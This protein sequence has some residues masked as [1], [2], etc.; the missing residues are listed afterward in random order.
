M[1]IDEAKKKLNKLFGEKGKELDPDDFLAGLQELSH[2][3]KAVQSEKIS[4]A[5]AQ[6]IK[7][8]TAESKVIL[9]EL[10]KIDL[11]LQQFSELQKKLA[12][13]IQEN[14]VSR[15]IVENLPEPQKFPEFKVDFPEGLKQPP[16][17]KEERRGFWSE[18]LAKAIKQ[19][20]DSLITALRDEA[21]LSRKTEGAIAVRLVDK[22]GEMFYN[23]VL[24][25]VTGGIDTSKL[26]QE[27]TLTSINTRITTA[28]TPYSL[29]S[30][31]TTNATSVK[32]SA[33]VIY[34][35]QVGNINAAA[36]YLKLYNK[37]SAPTVG[38]D[39]P[40]KRLLIPGNTAGGGN[41]VP[42]P[43]NGISFTTGIAF[44]LTTGIADSDTTAVAANEILVNI[45]Y[46]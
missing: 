23:A 13:G 12:D 29:V 38:T 11:T 28:A 35:I 43:I 41:N 2:A 44:A 40:V 36:R 1:E 16:E 31:A 4:E 25:A 46:I 27:T 42:V 8:H 24:T 33:G 37:A 22:T 5:F 3:V 14:R 6:I 39:T 30:A 32:A 19:P 20:F 10:K 26:A 7:N 21:D 9:S 45:D 17:T 34:S 18:L 15:V